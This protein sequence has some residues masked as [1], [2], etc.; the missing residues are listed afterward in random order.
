MA[1]TPASPL[2]PAHTRLSCCPELPRE[3]RGAREQRGGRPAAEEGD[4]P[5]SGLHP[6]AGPCQWGSRLQLHLQP[7]HPGKS[8]R[9]ARGLSPRTGAGGGAGGWAPEDTVSSKLASGTCYLDPVD[10]WASQGAGGTGSWRG[11]MAPGTLPSA[12]VCVARRVPE[13]DGGG[14]SREHCPVT[15]VSRPSASTPACW[16]LGSLLLHGLG[17]VVLSCSRPWTSPSR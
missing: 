8:P 7:R 2:P 16:A 13:H 9:Q 10:S 4:R 12:C 1:R 3:R 11:G 6:Q 14:Q 5:G 17:P 15:W